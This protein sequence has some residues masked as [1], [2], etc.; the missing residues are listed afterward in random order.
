MYIVPAARI[1][2]GF[3]NDKPV[4]FLI[5]EVM[6]VTFAW[7]CIRSVN[8]RHI[9][10]YKKASQLFRA[11]YESLPESNDR[12]VPCYALEGLPA[13]SGFAE[14]A[15]LS[16]VFTAYSPTAYRGGLNDQGTSS[17]GSCGGSSCGGGSCGGGCG[18]C[19]GGD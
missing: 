10:V 15:F 13:V 4:L 1:V 5:I 3:I 8:A 19:G 2:Q 16:A 9:L 11:R 7:L 17:G 12:I 6:A 14:I 18:G